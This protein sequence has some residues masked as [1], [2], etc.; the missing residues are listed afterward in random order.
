MPLE[1]RRFEDYIRADQ[2][3][4]FAALVKGGLIDAKQPKKSKM[5]EF[6]NRKGKLWQHSLSITAPRDSARARELIAKPTLP[7]GKYL[8]KSYLD[9]TG[10]LEKD[11]QYRL[12]DKDLVGQIEIDSEWPGG[13]G[14][15]T[16]AKFP[17]R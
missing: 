11:W 9:Q 10:R 4:T 5:L 13:Y 7:S 1:R 16:A 17:G 15:M 14:S 2:A 8:V 12:G 6:I 3:E